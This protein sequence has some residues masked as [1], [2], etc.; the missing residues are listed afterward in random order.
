[1]W[2][3]NITNVQGMLPS[4]IDYFDLEIYNTGAVTQ[5]HIQA[6]S[7]SNLDLSLCYSNALLDFQWVVKED[8]CG[9]EHY[10]LLQSSPERNPSSHV[11]PWCLDRA[12]WA[13]FQE[14]TPA[15]RLDTDIPDVE[16]V[17][18][19]FSDVL[20]MFDERIKPSHYRRHNPPPHPIVVWEI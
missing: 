14:Q 12:A 3:D 11:P 7:A 20:R 1:M 6:D 16:G 4:F 17:V 5:Y 10:L 18:E 2:G 13:H 9:N 19:Y 15:G 8:L